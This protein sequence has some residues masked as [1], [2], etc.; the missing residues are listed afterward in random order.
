MVILYL[1]QSNQLEGKPRMLNPAAP[2]H[3]F[4]TRS[5]LTV[6]PETPLAEARELMAENRLRYLPVTTNGH[7]VGILRARAET[8]VDDFG[9]FN[10]DEGTVQGAMMPGPACVPSSCPIRDVVHTMAHEDI[11]AVLVVDAGQ[12]K[13]M[14]TGT[15]AMKLLAM[16]LSE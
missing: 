3:Q 10:V 12:L 1:Q 15:D 5:L 8:A 9:I 14:F 11:E 4:M 13:G 7:V 2:I 16:V 6:T